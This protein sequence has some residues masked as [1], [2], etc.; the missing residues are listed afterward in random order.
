LSLGR[1]LPFNSKNLVGSLWPILIIQ[2]LN[3]SHLVS[4]R[5]VKA[6]LLPRHGRL[7]RL[8]IDANWIAIDC[9]LNGIRLNDGLRSLDGIG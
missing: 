4:I 1:L 2:S 9:I 5:L 6:H 8:T 7:S 3:Q